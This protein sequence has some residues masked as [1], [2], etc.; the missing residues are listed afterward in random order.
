MVPPKLLVIPE[1]DHSALNIPR[2]RQRASRL[3]REHTSDEAT[4]A[5]FSVLIIATHFLKEENILVFMGQC[6]QVFDLTGKREQQSP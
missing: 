2:N 1:E 6:A 5:V 4:R 3:C